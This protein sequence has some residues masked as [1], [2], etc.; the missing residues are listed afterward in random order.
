MPQRTPLLDGLTLHQHKRLPS[1]SPSLLNL[2]T[3]LR[4]VVDLSTPDRVCTPWGCTLS[5]SANLQNALLP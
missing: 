2:E 5:F 3:T 1:L 4:P